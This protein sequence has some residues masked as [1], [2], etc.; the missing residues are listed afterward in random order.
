MTAASIIAHIAAVVLTLDLLGALLKLH[1]LREVHH[2]YLGAALCILQLAYHWP[3]WLSWI[4]I[5][6]LIDDDVQHTAEA[7]GHIPRMS[8]FTP[9]HKLG[10]WLLGRLQ[11]IDW[12]DAGWWAPLAIVAV[13]AAAA[14]YFA[15]H[16]GV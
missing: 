11:S 4:G 6:L 2:G 13:I 14:I 8:D 5:V 9:I 1:R 15:L 16:W 3:L 7:L 12:K 10:A